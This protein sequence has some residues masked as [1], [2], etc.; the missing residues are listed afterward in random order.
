MKVEEFKTNI[1]VWSTA[2]LVLLLLTGCSSNRPAQS[3]A[4]AAPDQ[5]AVTVTT[6][7]QEAPPTP[8]LSAAEEEE[9]L[10][11]A[12]E[13]AD[14]GNPVDLGEPEIEIVDLEPAHEKPVQS[15]EEI[16]QESLE[17]YESSRVFWE[18]GSFE[19]AFAALDQAYELM[20]S[21]QQNGDPV[22]AQEKE[23]LRH[24]IS[25]RVIEIYASR[26]TTVGDIDRSI[27]IDINPDV[28]REIKSFQ[29]P[30]RE[31]FL[32]S[33]RRSALYRPMILEK[34]EEAGLPEQISWL[35]LVESGFK[36][37]AYS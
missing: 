13:S 36:V 7:E 31:F 27:P 10:A 17:A 32:D 34:L 6:A 30:E 28:E 23:N 20:S 9:A 21:V 5:P 35:P 18:Q 37:K 24:L 29:G 22:V 14:N 15:P 3:A 26:Q 2:A 33:Y 16:L 8:E 4:D 19:D 25:R 11:T 12:R 1:A